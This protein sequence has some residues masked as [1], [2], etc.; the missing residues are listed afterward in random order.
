MRLPWLRDETDLGDT[1]T[2]GCAHRF[3]NEFVAHRPV[4]HQMQFGIAIVTH[5][6]MKTRFQ[7]GVVE[8]FAVEEDTAVSGD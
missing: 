8:L 3:G 2:A 6:F 5:G 4:S 1:G 7:H